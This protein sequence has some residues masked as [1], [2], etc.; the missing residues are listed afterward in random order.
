ML[1]SVKGTLG[2]A[3]L[4][5]E[6]RLRL[7]LPDSGQ[8]IAANSPISLVASSNGLGIE[9]DLNIVL[10]DSAAAFSSKYPAKI[11]IEIAGILADENDLS[12]QSPTSFSY[13]LEIWPGTDIVIT[14]QP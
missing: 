13:A 3:T 7:E 9:G 12:W 14:E 8:A 6:K 4:V 5:A 10:G 1:F 11:R 2:I